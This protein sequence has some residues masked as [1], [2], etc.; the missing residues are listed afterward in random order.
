AVT[1]RELKKRIQKYTYVNNDNVDIRVTEFNY[2]PASM[3]GACVNGVIKYI[4]N[5]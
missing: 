1:F 3:I 4:D 5:I 2:V